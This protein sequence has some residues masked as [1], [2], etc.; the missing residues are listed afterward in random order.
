MLKKNKDER[1]QM[2]KDVLID[3]KNLREN[4]AF[5]EKLEKSHSQNDESATAVLQTAT[6][7][8]NN[9]TNEANDN[10][11]QSIKRHKPIATLVLIALLV[12]AIGFGY[13][14]YYS[15]TSSSDAG[16][17]N[18]SPFCHLLIPDRTRMSNIC[19]TELLKAL[20][21]I[22]RSFQVYE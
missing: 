13:Y 18:R 8:A 2:M 10:F 4:L 14:F 3:L 11:T 1:Y 6:S 20:S 12:G 9:R 22:Y 15:K 16:S 7:D 17:K 5:D 19:R 21:T